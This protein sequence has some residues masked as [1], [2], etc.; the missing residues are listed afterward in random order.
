M[1]YG[2]LTPDSLRPPHQKVC[3]MENYIIG[4]LDGVLFLLE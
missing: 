1:I 4:A 2:V 3:G